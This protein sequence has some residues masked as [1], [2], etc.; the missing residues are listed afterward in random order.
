MTSWVSKDHTAA[1][2]QVQCLLCAPPALCCAFRSRDR[3]LCVPRSPTQAG[4]RPTA[5]SEVRPT[6]LK[7]LTSL[8]SSRRASE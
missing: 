3:A 7:V 2:A 8:Q 6:L 4:P 5:A 1:G